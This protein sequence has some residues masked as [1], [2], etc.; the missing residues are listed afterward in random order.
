MR[1]ADRPRCHPEPVSD[2]VVI[3]E[4]YCLTDR[5]FYRLRIERQSAQTLACD[6]VVPAHALEVLVAIGREAVQQNDRLARIARTEI[7]IGELQA[8]GSEVSHAAC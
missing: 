7:V 3:L 5:H 1:G 8:V 6:S 2:A 4:D